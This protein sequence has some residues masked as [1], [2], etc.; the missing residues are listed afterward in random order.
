MAQNT[1]GGTGRKSTPAGTPVVVI[2]DMNKRVTIQ[3]L[4]KTVTEDGMGGHNLN[5]P[6]TTTTAAPWTDFC[7]VWAQILPNAGQRQVVAGGLLVVFTHKVTVRWT[8]GWTVGTNV[9]TPNVMSIRFKYLDPLTGLTTL[10]RV[11]SMADVGGR[12]LIF[13]FFCEEYVTD[14][15]VTPADV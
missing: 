12:H 1:S 5:P 3:Q 11:K 15:N 8:S 13:E 6:S 2:P 10:Y 7:T 4:T 14:S 9:V